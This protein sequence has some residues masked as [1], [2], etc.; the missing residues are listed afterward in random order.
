VLAAALLLLSIEAGARVR[1]VDP[2][3][4]PTLGAEEGLL[5]VAV[6]SNVDL[7][8][9][10]V[11][12]EGRLL[13]SGVLSNI[14]AGRSARLYVVPAGQYEWEQIRAFNSVRYVLKDDP[15]YRFEVRPGVITY[16][17]DLVFRPQGWFRA[18]VHVANRGLRAMDWLEAQH[19][20]VARQYAFTYSGHYPDPFPAFYR[21]ARAAGAPGEVA[22]LGT[23]RKPPAPGTLPLA[24]RE[25]WRD[26]RIG[27]VS[28]NGAG[29]L[30][31]ER[32]RDKDEWGIDLIDLKAGTSVRLAQT[33]F[34]Y[35]SMTWS[36]DRTLLVGTGAGRDAQTITII[37][38]RDLAGGQHGFEI[39]KLRHAGRVLDP[40]PHDPDHILFASHGH[41]DQLL[42]HE[43]DIS[44]QR[45]LDGFNTGRKPLNKGV[46]DDVAWFTDGAGR[47]RAALARRDDDYVLLHG[48]GTTFTEVLR[49]QA[50]DGFEPRALSWDGDLVYGLTDE[51]RA[52]R[53]LVVFD[54]AQRRVTA[55]LFSKPGV[56][57]VGPIMDDRRRPIGAAYYEGGR[58]VSE[59]FD[60][61]DQ[62]LAGMLRNT[63]ANRTVAV[64][65]RSRDGQQ[66]V[67]WVDGSDQPGKLYHLDATR[68][69]ASLLD[70]ARPWLEGKRFVASEPF[71]VKGGDG[72]PVEAYLTLPPG[73]G[74]RPL[75]VMP[76][77]G[78]VG[79]SD[80]R[81]FNPQVQ[82]LASLGYAVLQVNF[83]G[84]DGYGKAFREAGYRSW[85]T[86]IEDDID[87][88]IRDALARHPLD[89]QRLCVVGASYG[90]YSALVAAIRWPERVR[91]AV[92]IAGVSDRVL[93][94]TASDA[95]HS[96]KGREQLE[97]VIGDPRTQL[98]A[99]QAS[100]PLY[101]YRELKAPVML[102]HG[103]EDTRVD[104]EHARRLVRMLN[105]AGR[106]PVML[107]FEDEGHGIDDIDHI[108]AAWSGIAGFLRE[109][110]DTPASP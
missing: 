9:V 56:D 23:V 64:I 94:F 40:L 73:E 46:A 68:N 50:E 47:L 101:R 92:S 41:K 12:K 108:E 34:P 28:L 93:F 99:M 105:L 35:V 90:G 36:G 79:V 58:L 21:A 102:V 53:D 48:T 69:E 71:S 54:P 42:V 8:A 15:E 17:G 78:P 49:L 24:I 43:I 52:Q 95:G 61:R 62:K 10:S 86:L 6:D 37:R 74:R 18:S 45:A 82:F 66:L 100:S 65:D 76:H 81:H 59:Y 7:N 110:L 11:K 4:T 70:D 60:Q 88:A 14:K 57:L 55:T 13:S 89:P 27:D 16:G 96:A 87:I 19:P 98:E 97:R 22:E 32:V 77:G 1:V 20:A 33:P 51:G 26:E 31:A 85:G 75:V 30:L 91:C 107:T 44:S 3:E 72:L 63:F 106:P 103:E 39:L 67:L 5:L 80:R 109:H 38:I 104:Y 29:D 83:R 2:G 84:S 25:L